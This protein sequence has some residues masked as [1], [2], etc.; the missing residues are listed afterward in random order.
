MSTI[1]INVDDKSSAKLFLDL[2][3]KLSFKAMILTDQ[4]KEDWALLTMMESR[5]E[6]PALP[7]EGAL[8][9]LSRIKSK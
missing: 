7:V 5:N 1:V 3:K 8:D 4:Q 9:I 6:E 2:A